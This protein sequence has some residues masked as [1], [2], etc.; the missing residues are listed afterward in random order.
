VRLLICAGG[1]GGGIYPA[2]SVLQALTKKDESVRMK[3]EEDRDWM[4]VNH[5]SPSIFHPSEVLW[6]GGIGGMET[7]LVKRAGV[8]FEAISAAGVHGVGLR[9]LPR[10][11]W[12]L[13]RG[14]RQARRIVRRFRPDILFFTGGYMGV[15]V[16]LAGRKIPS[17]VYVPD[18]E[19]GLALKVQ[20][21]FAS[22]IAV[23]TEDSRHYFPRHPGVAIT[24]YP[25]RPDLNAWS[26]EQAR[27]FM[28]TSV[29]LPTLL[30]FGGSRG[31]RSINQAL[32]SAL[33][34]LLKEM[35]VIHI[36]GQPDWPEVEA[37]RTSLVPGDAARYHAYTYL[38]EMGAALGAADLALTRAGASTLGELPLF[39]LPA[40]LVPYPYAWRYQ[41]TNAQYL[42]RRGAAMVLADADLNTQLLPVVRR[43]MGDQA[44][45]NQMS[46]LMRSLARPAAADS[47]ADLLLNLS[48][49]PGKDV[50]RG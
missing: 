25:T 7:D 8:P 30:V 50:S 43:L 29:D 23:S 21:R 26:P 34:A 22:R 40:I 9:A 35:Q 31:A 13:G 18:I 27:Q 28:G 48:A 19:P 6:V 14:Y 17:V 10:N 20:S 37:F 39:G 36:S 45:R 33:P 24:G 4:S 1:T 11:L 3:A 32:L 49:R 44:Q 2:L 46:Q 38:H 42:A 41:Q 15:P 5:P 16:A 47:I 12:L